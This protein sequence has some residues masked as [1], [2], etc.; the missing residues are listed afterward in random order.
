MV[1]EELFGA[2]RIQNLKRRVKELDSEISRA[3]KKKDFAG[4]KKLTDQQ[5]GLL[6][7]MLDLREAPRK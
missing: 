5:S 4:A 1:Q 7:E 2:S 6:K 3:M